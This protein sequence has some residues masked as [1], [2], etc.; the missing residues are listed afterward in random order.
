MRHTCRHIKNPVFV[1]PS[2][3]KINSQNQ[4][5]LEIKIEM[6]RNLAVALY[7]FAPPDDKHTYLSLKSGDALQIIAKDSSGWWDGICNGNQ[8]W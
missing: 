3:S 8:G 1:L 2:F 4:V 5:S 7:D 6:K